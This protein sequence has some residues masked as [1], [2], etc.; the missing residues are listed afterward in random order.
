MRLETSESPAVLSRISGD[1]IQKCKIESL[2]RCNPFSLW[3]TRLGNLLHRTFSKPH[4][5]KESP[6]GKP[7]GLL[8]NLKPHYSPTNSKDTS[9]CWLLH[10]SMA[11]FL[12]YGCQ[13]L[14]II[15]SS[16]CLHPVLFLPISR[17]LRFL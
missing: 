14:N 5:H 1:Y 8:K 15:E 2:Y 10:K 7:Y 6:Y 16:H 17:P 13:V 3:Y 11:Y 4:A 9:E 12:F